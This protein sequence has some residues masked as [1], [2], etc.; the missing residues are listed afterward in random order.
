MLNKNE[1]EQLINDQKLIENF[2]DL[3]TQLTPNGFDMTISKIF[4]YDS[5]G[6][7]DF[8]NNERVLP[9]CKE[10]MPVERKPGENLG[11]WDLQKGAYK[12]LTNETVNIPKDMI[13][14]AFTRSSLL[15]M[16]AFT[17]NGV[18]DAGFSGRSEFILIVENPFGITVKQNSRVIQLMFGKIN[19]I[20]EGYRGIYQNK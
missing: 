17:Q 3:K 12:V 6:A 19:E 10:L 4:A 2:I 20:S 15:R 18:W 14:I 7:L 13:A 8:S 11:W 5:Y 1:I 9:N 16:G